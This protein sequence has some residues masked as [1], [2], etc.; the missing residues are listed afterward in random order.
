MN[1]SSMPGWV[2]IIKEF[3]I[4]IS[5]LKFSNFLLKAIELISFLGKADPISCFISIAEVIFSL[6]SEMYWK[7]LH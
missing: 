4:V 7:Y 6:S 5:Y 1:I 2:R 3:I